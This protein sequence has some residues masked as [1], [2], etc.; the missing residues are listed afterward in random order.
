MQT[1]MLIDFDTPYIMGEIKEAVVRGV[2]ATNFEVQSRIKIKLSQPG[3][4]KLRKN[5]TRAS[6]PNE[7]P[8]P[9]SG[10]LR[11][12]F[13]GAGVTRVVRQVTQIK[14]SIGQGPPHKT[15]KYAFA[16][17][18]GYAP[19]NLLPRPFIDPVVKEAKHDDIATT[20]INHQ[21][22]QTADRLNEMYS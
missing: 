17:E 12:S 9:D 7:P 4:G 10:D 6:A 13:T 20:L 1:Q 22:Q 18:Y 5:G 14:G 3:T 21:V 15:K 2:T 11:R 16:L 19:R 8:A